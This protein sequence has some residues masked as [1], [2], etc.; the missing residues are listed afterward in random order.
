M[1]RGTQ[2]EN[3][4]EKKFMNRILNEIKEII[5]KNINE[6][7]PEV[8]PS[9]LEENGTVYY[10]NGK[11]GTEFDW[12]VNE[13]LPSFMVFYND[14]QNLG[15][16]KLLIYAN[17]KVVL[18]L[19]EDKGNKLIKEIETSIEIIEDELFKLAVILKNETEDK[20]I[21]DESIDKVNMDVE[22]TEEEITKFQDS[23]QYMKP[24]KNRMNLL[25]KMAYLS[26]KVSEDGWKVGYMCRE[27]AMNENDSGWQF[28][29]GNEDDKYLNNN[30]NCLLVHVQDVYQ[31]DPDIWN[32]IDNP[33]G[34]ELIRISSNEFEIDKKNKEIFVEKRKV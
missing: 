33:V 21:W 16:A 2:A 14:E 29:A 34:T 27:E 31:L 28:L 5:K 22:I 25:N 24:T 8:K 10:M 15:A 13:H 12:Y 11:N 19:Y 18:Y 26:K 9:D 17:G 7:L 23:E 20:D 30:K 32:Y 1:N 3:S 6:Y 4:E